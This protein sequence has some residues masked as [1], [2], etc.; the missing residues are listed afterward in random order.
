M[1]T[2]S[3]LV[4][5]VTKHW[6]TIQDIKEIAEVGDGKAQ[7][8]FRKIKDDIRSENK[9]VLRSHVPMEMVLKHLDID[10][11]RVLRYSNKGAKA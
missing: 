4:P 1:K 2:Y 7:Q 10:L 8:I 9:L 5:Y 11:N 3:E 6:A